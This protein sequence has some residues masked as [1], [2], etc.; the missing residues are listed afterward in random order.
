MASPRVRKLLDF[1]SS[2]TSLYQCFCRKKKPRK[3]D[4]KP[5]N[6]ANRHF[7]VEKFNIKLSRSNLAI[8]AD[9]METTGSSIAR[10]CW[11]PDE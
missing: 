1:K 11:L 5:V 3:N 7:P 2:G 8:T 10:D 6:N 9:D 4:A